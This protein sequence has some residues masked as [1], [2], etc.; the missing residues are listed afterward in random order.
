MALGI[1]GNLPWALLRTHRAGCYFVNQVIVFL[2]QSVI[3]GNTVARACTRARA[4]I[5]WLPGGVDVSGA[6]TLK[7]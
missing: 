4:S 5:S 1:L 3:T 2:E 7:Q 6:G